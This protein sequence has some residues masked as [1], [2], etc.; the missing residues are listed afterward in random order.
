MSNRESVD[1]LRQRYRGLRASLDDRTQRENARLLQCNVA[2][3][4]AYLAARQ[5]A[6]YIAIKGEIDVRP[7]IDEGVVRGVQFYLPILRDEQMVFAPWS[8]GEPLQKRGFGLLEPDVDD[9]RWCNPAALDLVLTPLVAFDQDCNRIGQG[10]GFY[11]RA[12]A[13]KKIGAN[14]QP[15]LLGVAHDCQRHRQLH[16]QPWDVPLDRVI[17]ERGCYGGTKSAR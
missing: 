14:R 13:F 4:P 2:S 12:F 15:L 3:E 16:A 17:T 6:A 5:V 7:I 1:Q 9:S 11:D 10:G 8:P